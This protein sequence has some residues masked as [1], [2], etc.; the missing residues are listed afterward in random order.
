MAMIDEGMVIELRRWLV[1][2]IRGRRIAAKKYH[3]DGNNVR[4]FKVIEQEATLMAALSEL[5]EAM[6]WKT[7]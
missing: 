2:A 4:Y 7:M 6:G 5:E 1:D 3:D